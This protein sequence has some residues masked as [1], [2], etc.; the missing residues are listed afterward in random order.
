MRKVIVILYS[1]IPFTGNCQL[2]FNQLVHLKLGDSFAQSSE[3]LKQ[4]LTGK[5]TLDEGDFFSAY[6]LNF[7]DLPIDY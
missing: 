4:K 3:Y 1:L 6:K 2:S 7:E 5:Y